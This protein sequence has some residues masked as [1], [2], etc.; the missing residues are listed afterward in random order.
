[1]SDVFYSV[2]ARRLRDYISFGTPS[3]GSSSPH[4]KTSLD[5]RLPADGTWVS[6]M[7]STTSPVSPA[8]SAPVSPE[9]STPSLAFSTPVSPAL[10][11]AASPALSHPVSPT[12]SPAAS[13]AL[14]ITSPSTTSSTL[15][16][17]T[18]PMSTSENLFQSS[19]GAKVLVVAPMSI[20]DEIFR[21]MW[22][23]END[24]GVGGELSFTAFGDAKLQHNAG[25]FSSFFKETRLN[26]RFNPGTLLQIRHQVSHSSR[27]SSTFVNQEPCWSTRYIK[28]RLR[29]PSSFPKKSLHCSRQAG[30]PTQKVTF[31]GWL[32]PTHPT[33]SA[34]L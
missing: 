31:G 23:A 8:L 25:D 12:L 4:A 29:P 24:R 3:T 21:G 2:L 15:T 13:P 22:R 14:S 33:T 16:S 26:T 5:P 19:L 17:S 34:K 28:P 6:P 20:H 32:R 7:L 30:C 18:L 11:P 27:R 9:L 10:S 1:M